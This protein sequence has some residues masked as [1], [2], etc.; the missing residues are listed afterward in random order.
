MKLSC[1]PTNS[2][3]YISFTLRK[4]QFLDSL[5]FMNESLGKLVDNLA[6]EGDQHFYHIKRHFTNSE[7]RKLLLRKRV[8]P[9]EWM[10][11][12]DIMEYT[13]LPEKEA[14]DSKL[15]LS[16]ISDDDYTHAK[17][18]GKHSTYKLCE[19]TMISI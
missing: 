13:S 11:H 5:N 10:D 2:E 9:Y 4:L 14:F 17:M 1:I 15:S 18:C 19:I 7:E 16:S 3:K 8:Y 12:T 6:A